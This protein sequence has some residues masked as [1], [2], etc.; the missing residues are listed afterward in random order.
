MQWNDHHQLEGKH[1]FLG[2]SNYHWINWNDET[3]ENR[4]YGQFS[5]Q[6]GTA[7]HALAH[8]CI[9]SRT[10]LTK[11]DTHLID[12]TLYHAYIPKDAYDPNLILNN[13]IPFI[14]DAIG[15]H[16]SSEILLYYNAYCFGTSDAISFD[17]KN[18]ML[19][20]HDLK[21]GTTPTHMEQLL[22]YA[23]LFCL[24]YHKNPHQFKT[25][26]RIYQ[27]FDV[28]ITNPEAEEIEQY[29]DLIQNRS[30]LIMSYLEREGK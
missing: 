15:F 10:K 13:L 5:T 7:I 30:K 26:L 16:M 29:M 11:H 14:N 6:I 20:I 17:E 8:D 23:A 1:A 25:E 22:I 4:Y 12:I 24:E 2:A 3:F 21:T 19:R 27:N 18:K 28:L 9:V